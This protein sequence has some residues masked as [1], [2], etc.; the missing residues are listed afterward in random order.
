MIWIVYMHSKRRALRVSEES[1]GTQLHDLI[2]VEVTSSQA[3][4]GLWFKNEKRHQR[5]H[6]CR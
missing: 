1:W 4:L 3:V 6:T 5:D 2:S